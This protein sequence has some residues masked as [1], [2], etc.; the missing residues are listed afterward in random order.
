MQE[1]NN[2]RDMYLRALRLGGQNEQLSTE[3][4][5]SE[6]RRALRKAGNYGN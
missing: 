5:E 1:E 4:R 2:L 3:F 6:I